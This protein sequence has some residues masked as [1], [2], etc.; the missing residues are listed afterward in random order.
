MCFLLTEVS[1]GLVGIISWAHYFVILIFLVSLDI[2]TPCRVSMDD[3]LLLPYAHGHGPSHSH[4]HVRDCQSV[5]YG[6][7]THESRPS[8]NHSGLPVA[9]STVFVE[10][11]VPGGSR[12]VYGQ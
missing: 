4:R 11:V 9:E 3:D 5:L 12:W 10:P 8:S 2:L 1:W 6:N 7:T